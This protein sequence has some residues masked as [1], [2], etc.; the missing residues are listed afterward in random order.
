MCRRRQPPQAA[1]KILLPLKRLTFTIDPATPLAQTC[2]RRR[3]RSKRLLPW[4]VDD[5]AKVP[6][7]RFEGA[8]RSRTGSV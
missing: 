7:I 3:R 6:E 1:A 2:C 4:L 8:H 5:L